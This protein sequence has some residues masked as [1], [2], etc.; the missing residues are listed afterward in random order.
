MPESSRGIEQHG[1]GSAVDLLQPGIF[2]AC[3]YVS[4]LARS[5]RDHRQPDDSSLRPGPLQALHIP[6]VVVLLRV[7]AT[8]VAPFENDKLPCVIGKL[9]Q[10][11]VRVRDRK[12]RRAFADA[13]CPAQRRGAKHSHGYHHPASGRSSHFSSLGV[14]AQDSEPTKINA[15]LLLSRHG[16]RYFK[17]AARSK[18]HHAFQRTDRL[19]KLVR[20][21]E[22]D[23]HTARVWCHALRGG[24]IDLFLF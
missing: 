15:R 9:L 16:R 5:R 19:Q 18:Y 17:C 14:S 4:L 21:F 3:G 8:P 7:R 20:F 10:L 23:H 22:L 2:F 6:A 12:I 1:R 11:A 24:I 13:R